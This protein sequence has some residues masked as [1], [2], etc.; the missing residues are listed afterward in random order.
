MLA[1]TARTACA[2]TTVAR[3]IVDRPAHAGREDRG[4]QP[5]F[6]ERSLL[7]AR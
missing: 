2:V 3:S 1:H 4:F 7:P 5:R 6:E